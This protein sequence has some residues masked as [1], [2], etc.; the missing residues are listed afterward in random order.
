[1]DN[2]I[3]HD[4]YAQINLLEKILYWFLGLTGIG[5]AVYA[6]WTLIFIPNMDEGVVAIVFAIMGTCPA[7][8]LSAYAVR[9]NQI[10]ARIVYDVAMD[11]EE[12]KSD[13][14]RERFRRIY[15]YT[16]QV[17][18]FTRYVK[19]VHESTGLIAHD[20]C[21]LEERVSEVEAKVERAEFPAITP[22]NHKDRRVRDC[23]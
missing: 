19:R 8:A 6:V 23:E 21:K 9:L 17:D 18:E 7:I 13:I 4:Y 2:R 20:V 1:M 14:S 3:E 5:F 16:Q 22:C 15:E 10:Q 12:V 11:T